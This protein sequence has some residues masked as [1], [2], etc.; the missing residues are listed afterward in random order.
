MI[1]KRTFFTSFLCFLLLTCFWLPGTASSQEA[2][3]PPGG[4]IGPKVSKIVFLGDSITYGGHYI[5]LI[6]SALWM[7][8][9]KKSWNIINLG[10]PS[11]TV[12]G[13]SEAGHANG[14]FPRPC[15]HTRLQ[16][17]LELSKPELVVICYGM[18]CGIYH[19][20]QAE[21]ARQFHEGMIRLR[22]AALACP[23][24]VLH[25]TPPPFDPVPI[26]GRL[27]PAGLTAYPKPFAEYDD[28]LDRYADWLVEKRP[29]NWD[30]ADVHTTFSQALKTRRVEQPSFTFCP[31]GIHPNDQGHELMAQC[32]LDHWKIPVQAAS[33]S[34]EKSTASLVGL[35]KQR[36]QLMKNAWLSHVG[37]D[38][39]GMEPGLPMAE[40]EAKEQALLAG[41][42][43][44]ASQLHA[45]AA[46]PAEVK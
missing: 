8:F 29:Q 15:I 22:K 30:V 43:I 14:K 44:K 18:N 17:A 39:P 11:E 35:V 38:R 33:L 42:A 13:L 20:Y 21:R 4:E 12:S 31:D 6:E 16:K 19:P 25:L 28:V 3:K 7:H 34:Q 45:A 5:E 2:A 40:A 24:E 32:V 23:A 41:I 37:H 46:A 1:R 26:R 36:Q 10:L 27:L 9:P